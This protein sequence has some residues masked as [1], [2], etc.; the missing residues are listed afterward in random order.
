MQSNYCHVTSGIWRQTIWMTVIFRF[1]LSTERKLSQ[2]IICRFYIAFLLSEC[3]VEFAGLVFLNIVFVI[4]QF[5][6]L[7][8]FFL[9]PL[10]K[11]TFFAV[12][13]CGAVL[14]FGKGSLYMFVQTILSYQMQPK[15]H[16]KQVSDWN[17]Y[18]LSGVE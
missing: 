6:L 18:W 13:V 3:P 7:T 4:L 5:L 14:T 8:Y 17:C 10:R 11:T 9:L 1:M 2:E 12:H 15:I 16:G